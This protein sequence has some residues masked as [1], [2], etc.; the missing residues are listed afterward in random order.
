MLSYL[1]QIFYPN[2]QALSHSIETSIQFITAYPLGGLGLVPWCSFFL[3]PEVV[4]Q[5]GPLIILITGCITAW[6]CIIW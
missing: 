6:T 4:P 1:Q 2:V 3:K 5:G